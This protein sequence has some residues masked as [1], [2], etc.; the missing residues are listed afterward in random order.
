MFKTALVQD[1]STW[2]NNKSVRGLVAAAPSGR[3]RETRAASCDVIN[4]GLCRGTQGG[5]RL[6]EDIKYSKT[7]HACSKTS[8]NWPTMGTTLNGPFMGVVSYGTNFKWS[9]YGGDQYRELE[10]CYNGIVLAIV[11]D[12]NK[13]IYIRELSICGGGRLERLYCTHIPKADML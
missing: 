1:S 11:L 2:L 4:T 3:S 7:K 5:V 9:I 12:P 6:K 13:E 8:L 10:Y